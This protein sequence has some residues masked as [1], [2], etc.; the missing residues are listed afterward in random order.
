MSAWQKKLLE[1][2]TR[3]E[4][5]VSRIDDRLSRIDGNVQQLL[6]GATG[7]GRTVKLE[8]RVDR[9]ERHVGLPPLDE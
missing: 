8:Q 2:L 5:T 3:L 6:R 4:A 7:V 1:T 9:I